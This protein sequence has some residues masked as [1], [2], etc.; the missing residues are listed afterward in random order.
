MFFNHVFSSP[1]PPRFSYFL[2]HSTICS[3]SLL[4]KETS[5]KLKIKTNTH[6]PN[7]GKHAKTKQNETKSPQKTMEFLLWLANYFCPVGL[8][9]GVVGTPSG[10]PLKRTDF[11]LPADSFLVKSDSLHPF[12]LS[13]ENMSGSNPCQSCVCFHRLCQSVRALLLPCW[14]DTM[15]LELSSSLAHAIFL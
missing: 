10:T 4:F 5:P 1:T 2:T 12:L 8:P 11:R 7:M 6:K 9:R 13:A 14:E 15:A 3:L